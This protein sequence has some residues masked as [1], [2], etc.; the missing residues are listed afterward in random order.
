MNPNPSLK[1]FSLAVYIGSR[2]V[3]IAP[4]KTNGVKENVQHHH[5]KTR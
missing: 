1:I 4:S 3:I 5:R 2:C